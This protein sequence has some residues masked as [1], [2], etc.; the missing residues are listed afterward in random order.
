[1]LEEEEVTSTD[2][3]PDT[4]DDET[5]VDEDECLVEDEEETCVEDFVEPVEEV[6]IDEVRLGSFDVEEEDFEV[7]MLVL[8]ELDTFDEVETIDFE[9]EELEDFWDDVE[10]VSFAVKVEDVDFEELEELRARLDVFNDDDEDEELVTRHE[11]AEL[12]RDGRFE[13]FDA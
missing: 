3:L 9:D 4:V 5:F 13:H 12:S 2:N 10:E 8:V 6:F 1:M 11:Q 7:N